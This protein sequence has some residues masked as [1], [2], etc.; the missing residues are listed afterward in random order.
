[1]ETV[2]ECVGKVW[3]AVEAAK[4][5]M[6]IT[7]DHGNADEMF[8]HFSGQPSTAHSLNPTPFILAGTDVQ[9]LRD[10]G[11]FGDVAPTVLELLGIQPPAAMTGR[12]L[13]AG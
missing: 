10:G 2:D 1:V 5:A 11:D 8:D 3:N 6:I 9:R 13:I 12:S 7:A 4:G